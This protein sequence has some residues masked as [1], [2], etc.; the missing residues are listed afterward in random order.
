MQF[1]NPVEKCVLYG[2]EIT[3]TRECSTFYTWIHTH[4]SM[5]NRYR[6]RRG[7]CRRTFWVVPVSRLS[8]QLSEC[9]RNKIKRKYKINLYIAAAANEQKRLRQHNQQ[10][11]SAEG[12]GVYKH[13]PSYR[14][15][16]IYIVPT[17]H[18]NK[19]TYLQKYIQSMYIHT[20]CIQSNSADN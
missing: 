3:T 11:W 17:Q 7:H 15:Y 19:L 9:I 14:I 12:S 6:R 20:Y 5:Y 8:K 2:E 10:L 4:T 13:I 1:G 18:I 16:Y